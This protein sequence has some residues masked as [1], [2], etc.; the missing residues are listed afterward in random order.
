MVSVVVTGLR[1][2]LKQQ[3]PD[4]YCYRYQGY[5]HTYPAHALL[6]KFTGGFFHNHSPYEKICS[7]NKCHDNESVLDLSGPICIV[8]YYFRSQTHSNATIF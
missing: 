3:K 1:G 6:T 2:T 7:P 4:Q 8:L 5:E